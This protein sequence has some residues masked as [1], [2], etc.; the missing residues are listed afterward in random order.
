MKVA[1]IVV[2]YNPFHNGHLYH[3]QKTREIT[4]AD[5]VVGVMSG[6]FIQRGEPAIVNK[7]AR[8]KMAILNGVDVI[9][10]LPF[11]YACNS[12]E[13]FAYGAISILNQLGVDF[14]VFGSECGDIDKLKE[15]AKH[16]AFEED[17]FKSS[18][19]SYLKEG[20]SFPKA[21][22]LALIKTCKTN[23]EFSS[24][25]ILGIE[26]IK[27]IYRLSSKIEPL[28]IKRIGA[29]YN[30]PNLTQDTYASATAIRR[31]I[32]NLQAIKN[33]MPSASYEILIEEFESGRGPVFLEDYF[34]LFIYNAIVVPDFL[35]NKIDVKEGLENRFEKYIFNS[36]SA[37]NLLENVKTKR[38][39]L[40]RLQR[41]FIHAIVRNN[42]D[43]KTLLSITPYVRVLGFNQKGK[44]YLNKIKDKI[45]Y[46]TKLN[47]QW[48]KNPQYKELL[49][50]E[51][52]SSMLH[53]LQYR[54]FHKYLQ[55]EFK[56]S[57]IYISSR[58]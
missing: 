49:E 37:K 15:T 58:S 23:I 41:I 26:Y 48:L 28:T 52:R 53:A 7:W 6:N 38:Y 54:D 36:P 40:T 35:K 43:Q 39:T 32:N 29:S 13:I 47:Q 45:E 10:E 8:T 17:D 50:L 24:N 2:E 21:R 46:I 16:L 9:F 42:F 12:A 5:I 34:K 20:Y 44:E 55:T 22:E 4:N 11:A 1:G 56:S 30:D 27:W 14:I 51:I 31:N 3:L 25:N 19:K 57:P 33:K 18:L